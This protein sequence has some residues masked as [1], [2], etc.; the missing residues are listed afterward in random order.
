MIGATEIE[1]ARYCIEYAIKG[2][3]FAARLS[4]NKNVMDA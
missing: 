1:L 3:A 4:L 2:G